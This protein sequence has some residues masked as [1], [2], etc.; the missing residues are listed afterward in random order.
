MNPEQELALLEEA[1]DEI[2]RGVQETI[3][4]GE[5]LS[6]ELQG[7]LAE[8]INFTVQ[9][10]D[11]LTQIIRE[12]QAI[13]EFTPPPIPAGAE[14]IWV[15]SGGNPQVFREYLQTFPDPELNALVRNPTQLNQIIMRLNDTITLPAGEVA[16]GVPRADIQ[17]SNVYGYKYD[18]RKKEM[19]VKFQGNGGAGQGPVYKYENVPAGV[20]KMIQAGAV[21]ARTNGQNRWG[22]WWISK[23][24]SLGASVNA[25]LVQGGFPYSRVS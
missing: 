20:F 18:P 21:P 17:S 23:N 15:L 22:R 11:E 16:D 25:L 9:R 3:A 13:P 6:D 5:V 1:L 12:E 7:L 14:L 24:P 4:S 8:E 10:I 19:I 2:I